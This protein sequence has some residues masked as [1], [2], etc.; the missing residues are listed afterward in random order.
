M[1]R[2]KVADLLQGLLL[3]PPPL[4]QLLGRGRSSSS[5]S[6]AAAAS[7]HLLLLQPAGGHL[8]LLVLL[9]PL[10][11][12]QPSLLQGVVRLV[13][14]GGEGR[15]FMDLIRERKLTQ[16]PA[17]LFGRSSF[18]STALR[19]AGLFGSSVHYDHF[20]LLEPTNF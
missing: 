18:F 3:Q 17:E 13:L 10:G 12:Q 19:G 7:S 16:V 1:P 8:G 5:A 14:R 6:S 20:G 4:L 15:I 9:V 2:E 11:L